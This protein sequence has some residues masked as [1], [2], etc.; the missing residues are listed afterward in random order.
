MIKFE[1][2]LKPYEGQGWKYLSPILN[3]SSW[4]HMI[5]RPLPQPLQSAQAKRRAVLLVKLDL[6]EEGDRIDAQGRISPSSYDKDGI[7]VYTTELVVTNLEI[8]AQPAKKE[9]PAKAKKAKAA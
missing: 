6:L 5:L 8:M 3:F 2:A 1:D 7:K 9:A 4:E